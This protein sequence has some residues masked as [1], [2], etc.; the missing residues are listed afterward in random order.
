MALLYG[1]SELR[2]LEITFNNVLRKIWSLP[3]AC[4]TGILLQVA[5]LRSTYNVVISRLLLSALKSKSPVLIDV[6]TQSPPLAY[7][8]LGYNNLYGH[9]HLKRYSNQDLT[10]YCYYKGHDPSVYTMFTQYYHGT[11]EAPFAICIY[12]HC[13]DGNEVWTFAIKTGEENYCPVLDRFT[14]A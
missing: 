10:Y 5:G 14:I 13:E 4:H 6:F 11:I 1:F 12:I 2:S 7:T 3:C 9:H 8:S